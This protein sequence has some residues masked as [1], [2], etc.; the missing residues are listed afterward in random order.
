MS[1]INVINFA[2]MNKIKKIIF[3]STFTVYGNNK[4][5]NLQKLKTA[6]LNPFTQ[7][8]NTQVSDI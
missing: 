6:I 3:S 7:Y 8:P 2:K 1:T 5:K 4:K